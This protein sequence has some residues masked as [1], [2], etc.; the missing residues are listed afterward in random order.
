MACEEKGKNERRMNQF[1]KIRLL[2]DMASKIAYYGVEHGAT[3]L[4]DYID[5]NAGVIP[6][7]DY[8]HVI[9]PSSQHQFLSMYSQ[10]AEN[11][12]AFAVSCLLSINPDYMEIISNF[13]HQVGKDMGIKKVE[14]VEEAFS[15]YKSFILDGMPCD[16]TLQVTHMDEISISWEKLT[17][18]HQKAWEKAEG[19]INIYYQLQKS[20]VDGLF[21]S[22]GI[23]FSIEEN[24]FF[25]LRS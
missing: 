8:E 25:T 7:G 20:F 18:T 19:D 5:I 2:D 10:V 14:S 11:R 17:D 22:C 6:D 1:N 21:S 3:N 9:D 13:C 4:M 12:F 24:K 16:E 15:I 23:H